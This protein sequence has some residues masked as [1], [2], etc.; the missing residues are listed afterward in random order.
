MR[1][2][3]DTSRAAERV[4]IEGYRQM[5]PAQKLARVVSMNRALVQLASARL[6]DQ[7]GS[8]M[9]PDELRLRLAALRLDAKLM[10]EAFHWDPSAHGL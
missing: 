3:S 1:V 9:P 10:R 2:P 5:T 7:Y 8:D 4:I 6:R